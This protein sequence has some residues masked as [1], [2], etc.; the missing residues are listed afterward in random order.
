[1][2]VLRVI[3]VL[4]LRDRI[5]F[6]LKSLKVNW[7]TDVL[8]DDLSTDDVLTVLLTDWLVDWLI[9]LPDTRSK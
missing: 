6:K 8:T 9:Y 4:N 5:K 2:A 1:M 7:L 3:Q